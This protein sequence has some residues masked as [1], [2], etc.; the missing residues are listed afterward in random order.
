MMS[1]VHVSY[2]FFIFVFSRAK[3]EVLGK[4][5]VFTAT[6]G[7]MNEDNNETKENW[8]QICDAIVNKDVSTVETLLTLHPE[9]AHYRD[10][11]V[12]PSNDTHGYGQI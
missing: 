5:K 3:I 1:G 10:E 7:N 12:S 8:G 6:T 2:T 11:H 4:L 9:L